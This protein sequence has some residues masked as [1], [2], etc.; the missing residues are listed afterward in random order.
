MIQRVQTIYLLLAAIVGALT[1]FLPFA[2]FYA[3]GEKIAEYAMFGVF[4][5]Q[6]DVLE[7]TGP[8]VFPEWIFGA[9]AVGIP[10]I[11][12]F[13]YRNRQVQMRICRL[14]Y[15]INIGY[16]VYLVFAVNAIIDTLFDE[17]V[18]TM[19]HA[20]FYMPVAAIAFCFL[21]NRGIKKDEEL[22]RSIDRI[23]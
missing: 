14:A 11:A 22:V 8:Y 15:L 1:F 16:V 19:Y 3:G 9:F 5:V 23:R 21:A 2:H 13:M 17:G 10:L 18:K 7:M 12:L 4:N 20:G 6:S